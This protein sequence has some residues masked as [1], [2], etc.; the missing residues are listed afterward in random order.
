MKE[1]H[2]LNLKFKNSFISSEKHHAHLYVK[3]DEIFIKIFINKNNKD[4]DRKFSVSENA[5]GFFDENFGII[6]SEKKII[7][8]KSR[9]WKVTSSEYKEGNHYFT[10]Y[11]TN[12]LIVNPNKCKER[13]SQGKAFLNGNGLKVCNDFYSFFTNFKDKNVFKIGRMKGMEEFYNC[14]NLKFRPELDFWGNDKRDSEEYTIKRVPT[15]NYSF[16]NESFE[17]IR[18]KINVI[19]KFL[20]FYYGIRV[21]YTNLHYR[22]EDEVYSYS[23]YD[24]LNHIYNSKTASIFRFLKTNYRIEKILTSNWFDNYALNQDKI[25]RAIENYLHSRE[26]DGSAKFLLLFSIIEIFNVQQ[27]LE[28]FE[29]NE[30][31]DENFS[32]AFELIENALVNKNEVDLLKD[33]WQGTINKLSIKPMK[34]P[35]EETLRQ[36]GIIAENYGISFSSLKKVR[37][38]LTHGSIASINDEKLKEYTYA[39]SKIST[40]LILSKLGFKDDLNTN[41]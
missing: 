33:K 11:L 17:S 30:L 22:T 10:I 12:V 37:D 24:K 40:S 5:L 15:I 25:D 34:S 41:L 8:D 19:C 3:N 4:V 6:E 21:N 39:V 38:K 31:K 27:E 26:V 9:I 1:Y 35:L 20:S 16:E 7:F 13:I 28:K 2:C 23:N 18:N 14:G 36:N 32:K 29:F